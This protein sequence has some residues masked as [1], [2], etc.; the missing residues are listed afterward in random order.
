MVNLRPPRPRSALSSALFCGALVAGVVAF[1]RLAQADH[2]AQAARAEA[3]FDEARKLMAAKDFEHACPKFAESQTL[4]PAPGTMLN[5]ATCYERAGKTASAWGAFKAAQALAQNA[6][7]K[8]RA[9]AAAAKAAE[10]EPKVGHIT[11]WIAPEARVASLEVQC[12]GETVRPAEWG[13]PLPY[14]PGPHE[15]AAEAPGHRKWTSHVELRGDGQNVDITVP[16]LEADPAA[17]A[18]A[19]GPAPLPLSS[20]SPTQTSPLGDAQETP[21]SPPGMTQRIAGLVI[22]GIG[23]AGIGFGIAAYVTANAKYQDALGFCPGLANGTAC[24]SQDAT[25]KAQ[26]LRDGAIT[27]S[28]VSTV[29]FIA[30]GAAV[31]GGLVVFFTAPRAAGG[32]QIGIGPA[33]QGT[34]LSV[35]GRF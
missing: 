14:D 30:G 5:L 12:D 29:S 17:R 9:A 32:A 10:I 1:P 3:L 31:A 11:V 33:S 7:Q 18:A 26:P 21:S 16:A 25:T 34:G 2:Y 13:E 8:Q 24:P 28:T 4:D 35:S 23:V 20:T 27:W 15:L 22:A 19:G 6:G